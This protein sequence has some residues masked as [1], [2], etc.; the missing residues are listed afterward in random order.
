MTAAVIRITSGSDVYC[1]RR[2]CMPAMEKTRAE[3]ATAIAAYAI[4][5][6]KCGSHGTK[7]SRINTAKMAESATHPR[8]TAIVK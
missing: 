8:S 7:L 6:Y 2:L 1:Q 4:T 3:V 5:A